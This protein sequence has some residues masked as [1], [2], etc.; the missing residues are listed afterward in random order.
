MKKVEKS[1]SSAKDSGKKKSKVLNENKKQEDDNNK[2]SKSA[3]LPAKASSPK[4]STNA[5]KLN[6]LGLD[7]P[8]QNG[9]GS[10]RPLVV[11]VTTTPILAAT[12]KSPKHQSSSSKH[13]VMGGVN[14]EA[15]VTVASE[16]S[17]ISATSSGGA[18]A[19]HADGSNA[20]RVPVLSASDAAN[21]NSFIRGVSSTLISEKIKNIV[22]LLLFRA[23]NYFRFQPPTLKIKTPLLFKYLRLFSLSNYKKN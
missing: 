8:Y 20:A 9:A 18:N 22:C 7:S 3:T 10:T 12:P 5:D 23:L 16:P 14:D 1:S 6:T 21:T 17:P 19:T 15:A 13:V 11:D 2:T 4:K